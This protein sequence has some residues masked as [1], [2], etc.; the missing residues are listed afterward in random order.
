MQT[1][2]S[3]NFWA[4]GGCKKYINNSNSGKNVI[5]AWENSNSGKNVINAREIPLE[6]R[7]EE[8]PFEWGTK[9]GIMNGVAVG[10]DLKTGYAFHWQASKMGII[11]REHH[12]ESSEC[13]ECQVFTWPKHSLHVGGETLDRIVIGREEALTLRKQWLGWRME[14]RR[15]ILKE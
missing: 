7:E 10:L 8:I 13:L 6:F 15:W 9:E 5:N 4:G 12:Q 11:G 3:R 14:P 1:L 2:S